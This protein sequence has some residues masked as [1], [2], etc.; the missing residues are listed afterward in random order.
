MSQELDDAI[1]AVKSS[2]DSLVNLYVK[3][4]SLG[5]AKFSSERRQ[6]KDMLGDLRIIQTIFELDR[7]G[8][9]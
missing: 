6:L 2:Q 5:A 8:E 9:R 3:M 7:D 1:D 4:R